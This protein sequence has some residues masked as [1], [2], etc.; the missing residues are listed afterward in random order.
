MNIEVLPSGAIVGT[1]EILDAVASGAME[2]GR[3]CDCYWEGKDMRF[4]IEG[5]IGAHFTF[6]EMMVWFFSSDVGGYQ[7]SLDLF[8]QYGAHWIPCNWSITEAEYCSNK[9]LINPE[10][11]KGLTIRGVGWTGMI[12]NEPE[13]GAAGTMIPPADVYTAL[14]R[15]VIDACELGNPEGNMS[16]GM[17]E[18][19]KYQGFPGC[20][21]L[22]QTQGWIINLDLW[23]DLPED[24]Q[25]VMEMT[26][27]A[28]I[29]R[30]YGDM[31]Y[32]SAEA[33]KEW[34]AYSPEHE[35]VVESPELQALWRD[36]S[37]KLADGLAADD[38]DFKA[39]WED[40]KDMLEVVRHYVELQTPD[41]G[42]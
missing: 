14:E 11:F 19:T 12:V 33:V 24:I 8:E 6:D 3:S 21:Q 35:S 41:W 5:M 30:I 29:P 13:F 15:G 40:M 38:A 4:A 9:K 22:T 2:I 20:H 23:N 25:T 7:Q 37:W 16:L 39:M 36:T 17:H 1:M 26:L 31:T 27:W 34:E 28:S 10:D 18:V 32:R 42:D